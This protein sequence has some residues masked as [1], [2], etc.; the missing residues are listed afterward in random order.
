[1]MLYTPKKITSYFIFYV[2]TYELKIF[3]MIL[4]YLFTII[5]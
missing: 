5:I 4:I 3:V 2:N 1:M